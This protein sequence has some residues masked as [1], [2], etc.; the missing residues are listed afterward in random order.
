[1]FPGDNV[2]TTCRVDVG[3]KPQINAAPI[4]QA[5]PIQRREAAGSG[6]TMRNLTVANAC[7]DAFIAAQAPRM[8]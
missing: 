7:Y 1:M 6:V 2:W 8:S 5:G 4:R 3:T